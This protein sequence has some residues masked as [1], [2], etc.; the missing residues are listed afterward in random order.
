MTM[1]TTLL[2]DVTELQAKTHTIMTLTRNYVQ[3][4]MDAV[5]SHSSKVSK[6]LDAALAGVVSYSILSR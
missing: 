1:A 6:P 4:K 2:Y 5:F 3:I